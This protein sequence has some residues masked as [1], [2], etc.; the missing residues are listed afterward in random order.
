MPIDLNKI[1]EKKLYS[2]NEDVLRK[3][4]VIPLLEREQC[5]NVTD[6]MV[7]RKVE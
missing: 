5:F 2:L 3:E 7:Q 6:L 4:V 1:T